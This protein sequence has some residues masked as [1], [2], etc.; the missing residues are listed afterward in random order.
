M[1]S[2]WPP[3]CSLWFYDDQREPFEDS[4]NRDPDLADTL[5]LHW[6]DES[7]KVVFDLS[8][9][10]R[11]RNWEIWAERNVQQIVRDPSIDGPQLPT[12]CDATPRTA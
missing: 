6:P 5:T 9:P 4:I 8:S 11:Q 2:K 7:R 12:N 1:N 3:V 10:S